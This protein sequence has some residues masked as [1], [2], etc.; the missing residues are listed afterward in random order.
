MPKLLAPKGA[1]LKDFLAAA[2]SPRGSDSP[3]GCHKVNC[4]EAAREGGLGHSTLLGR[5]LRSL[6]RVAAV[7]GNRT[8]MPKLSCILC[9]SRLAWMFSVSFLSAAV[10]SAPN[11]NSKGIPLSGKVEEILCPGGLTTSIEGLAG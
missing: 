6:L 11:M 10:P 3:L 9:A 1:T 5:S 4:R 8:S 2:R 7:H